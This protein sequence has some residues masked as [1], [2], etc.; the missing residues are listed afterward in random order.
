MKLE[1]YKASLQGASQKRMM[2]IIERLV[3]IN[4]KRDMFVDSEITAEAYETYRVEAI[5]LREEYAGL[6]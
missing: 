5:A 4:E 6:E 3:V 1:Y 2:E